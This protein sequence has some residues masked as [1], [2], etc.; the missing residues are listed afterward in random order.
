MAKFTRGEALDVKGMKDKKLRGQLQYNER[1]AKD[2]AQSA[3]KVDDYLLT[4]DA[5]VLEAEGME[6]TWRF[7]QVYFHMK[8]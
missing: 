3:A 7:A 1:L 5:G 8:A 6:R 2:A 4:E